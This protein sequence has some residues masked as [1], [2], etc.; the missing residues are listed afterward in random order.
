MSFGEFSKSH[1]SSILGAGLLAVAFSIA[2]VGHGSF[3]RFDDVKDL[4]A[5]VKQTVAEVKETQ[6]QVRKDMVAL[7]AQVP[8]IGQEA[9]KAGAGAVEAFKGVMC[10]DGEDCKNAEAVGKMMD[11][12][13]GTKAAKQP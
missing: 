7:R 6:E 10:K 9:G 5:D 4:A 2:Y 12:M 13:R 3:K 11:K 8:A 1:G